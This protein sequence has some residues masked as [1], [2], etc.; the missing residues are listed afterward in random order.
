MYAF[1]DAE[2]AFTGAGCGGLREQMPHL[3]PFDYRQKTL[4]L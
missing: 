1:G 4:R 3:L 2:V